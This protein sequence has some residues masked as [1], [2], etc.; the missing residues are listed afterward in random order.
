MSSIGK[1]LG[2]N[3]E[4]HEAREAMLYQARLDS[5]RNVVGELPTTW[6]TINA[7]PLRSKER[8]REIFN[9]QSLDELKSLRDVLTDEDLILQNASRQALEFQDKQSPT[10]MF[11]AP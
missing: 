8:I 1:T 2:F 4:S 6:S 10:S 7:L 5:L 9:I 3:P 11:Q